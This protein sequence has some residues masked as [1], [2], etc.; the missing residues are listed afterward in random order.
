[1]PYAE[2]FTEVF[3]AIVEAFEDPQI[4]FSCSR[5][6]DVFGGG[7]IIED[8]LRGIGNSEVVIAD[9]T[10][11]NPNVFYELGI[12]H[13]IRD[14]EKVIILTQQMDDVPFDLQQFRCIVYNQSPVGL[15]Q[16][17]RNL[18]KSI[19]D[20]SQGVYRFSIKQGQ[21]YKFTKR[22]FGANEDR[23]AYDFEIPELWILNHGTKF[24]LKVYQHAIGRP[25]KSVYSNSHGIKEGEPMPMPKIPWLLL[26]ERVSND[27]AYFCLQPIKD[28]DAT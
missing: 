23:C 9:V 25:T 19:Q 14:I 1:M 2:Q 11:K 13:M 8:I 10:T 26:L 6:D 16:L 24:A 12:A 28:S 17:Q 21:V 5:A 20:I 7:H 15:R 27:T 3:D 22:L 4:G 18:I